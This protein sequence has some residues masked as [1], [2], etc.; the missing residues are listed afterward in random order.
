MAP[1]DS[2]LVTK[3]SP[4]IEGQVPD[5]IQS[6]HP[7][8]VEFLKQYY[9]FLEA[10]ELTVDG[11]IN[12]V[13]QETESTNFIWGEDETRI[14]LE[15]GGGT[16]GKFIEGEI[17]T[18][19]T[20]KAT[21]TVLVDDLSNDTSRMFISS[22]QKFEIGET[23]T[24]STSSATA[25]V[26]TY[27]ANPVQT[28]QQLLDYANTDNTTSLML[29]EMQ[30]Q[31]MD[32]IP[33]T[34]ASGTSK[35]N[36]IK[37]IK[38]LYAAKGTSEGH[39]LFL[40]LMFDEEAET[41]YPT[42]YMLRTSDGNWNKP[43]T[44]R[45]ENTPGAVGS[46]VI[47]Q[48]LT[49]RTS[50][51]TVFII[52]A[53]ELIQGAS[54]VTEFEIDTDS[55]VGTFVEGET[56]Y[57]TGVNSDV[58]QRFVIQ[59]IVTGITVLD[60]GILY[61]VGDNITLDAS[62]GNGLAT[63]T[64]NTVST[65][66]VNEIVVDAGGSNY[67]V[68]DALVFS[69]TSA[70]ISATGY[71]S[72]IGG[73]MLSEASDDSDGS[74]DYIIFE[75]GTNACYP[76]LNFSTHEEDTIV[77]NGTDSSS[78]DANWK[79]V[80][81]FGTPR[82]RVSD[83]SI[84]SKIVEELGTSSTYGEIAGVKLTSG[85]SGYGALPAI[86]IASSYGTGAIIIPT[87][88]DIGS[89]LDAEILDAGFLY[90]EAPS[91]SVPTNFI[92]KDV[93]GTFSPAS[94]LSSHVGTV[95]SYDTN[96]QVLS[97]NI[98]DGVKVKMEQEDTIISQNIEQEEN[99]EVF[100]SRILGDNV[101]QSNTLENLTDRG[102]HITD[103]VGI[104]AQ[105]DLVEGFV[106]TIV[107]DAE[108]I[109]INQIS[110]ENEADYSLDDEK[111]QLEDQNIAGV[112]R[113]IEQNNTFLIYVSNQYT[114]GGM[115]LQLDGSSAG[116]AI[117][118]NASDGSATD[119]GDEILLDRTDASGTD[120]GSKLLQQ[121]DDEGDGILYESNPMVS[122][123]TQRK[124]KFVLDG[125]KIQKFT[126]GGWIDSLDTIPL[127]L[128]TGENIL[129]DG[130]DSNSLDS[131]SHLLSQVSDSEQN[132]IRDDNL[133]SS[134]TNSQVV[135]IPSSEGDDIE[136]E[137]ETGNLLL[138]GTTRN[139]M[140]F[141]TSLTTFH[142]A[143]LNNGDKVKT[144]GIN[145]YFKNVPIESIRALDETDGVLLEDG[146]SDIGVQSLF[147][148]TLDSTAS[149]GVDAGDNI[150]LED[151]INEG[152]PDGGRLL[153]ESSDVKVNTKEMLIL[154]GKDGNSSSSDI[155]GFYDIFENKTINH[156]GSSASRLITE[157]GDG[158]IDEESIEKDS[159]GTSI[160]IGAGSKII[161][162]SHQISSDVETIR[163]VFDQTDSSGSN[164]GGVLKADGI[165]A[166]ERSGNL[167]MQESGI[168]AGVS[169]TDVGENLLYEAEAFLTGNIILDRTDDNDSDFGSGLINETEN[170]FKGKTLTTSGGATG[171]VI[172]SNIAKLISEIDFITTK[173]GNY[174]NTDSLI[175]E[176]VVRIQDSYYYQD[177]SY[178]VR[179]GQSVATYMNE[180]K[181]A[182]HPSGF[183]AFG[184]VSFATLI[185][186]AMPSS[187]GGGRIDVPST[188]FTPELAS[189]LE[190]I[191]NLR[192]K[193]RLDIPKFY[194]SGNLFQKLMLESGGESQF[195]F[196][197]DGTD[198]G[199]AAE[200]PGFD[201][202]ASE[203]SDDDGD[204][205][206]ITGSDDGSQVDA[207][208][209]IILEGTD[210]SGTNNFDITG[211]YSYLIL[212]GTSI[213]DG[214]LND[215]GSYC[216]LSGSAL[217]VYN[218]VD[219]DSDSLVLNGTDGSSTFYRIIH[220]DGNDA[221]SRI[222]TDAII[223]D[224]SVFSVQHLIVSE[225]ANGDNIILNRTD[226]L[227]ADAN[228]KLVSESAA[229]VGDND[230]DKLFLR[231]LTVKISPP[232]PKIL[233]SYGL[234]LMGDGSFTEA[235]SVSTIQLEDALRK[236]GPTINSDNLI[237]DG[238]DVGEKGDV[239][240]IKYGGDPIQLE[241]S[242]ALM[243]G[244]SVS[245]DDYAQVS[246]GKFSLSAEDGDNLALDN[247]SG[248]ILLSEED[249]TVSFPINEFLR[250][251]IMVME[252]AYDRHSEWGRF[253]L[254]G[255]SSDG[256][257]GALNSTGYDY[258]V[259]DGIDAM[260]SG[261]DDNLIFEEQ[262][263]KNKSID[264]NTNIGILM[265]NHH[266]EGG[267]FLREYGGGAVS[268]GDKIILDGT[269]GSSTDAEDN[270]IQEN[271]PDSRI[272]QNS[273]EF[274]LENN[275]QVFLTATATDANGSNSGRVFGLEDGT[276][277]FLSET[278]GIPGQ[279]ILLESGSSSTIGS[280]L[281]L[282]SQVIEI[283]SGIND[284]EIPDPNIGDNS[285]FPTYSTPAI[286][287]TRP[288][289]RM[290]L[291]DESPST[292]LSQEGDT[293]DDV[294]LDGTSTIGSIALNGTN[295]TSSDE[296]S[297]LILDGTDSSSDNIGDKVLHEDAVLIDGGGYILISSAISDQASGGLMEMNGTDG[298]ST[299]AG[300]Y[301]QFE[302]GTH[303][304]L[305]G[306][307]PGFLAPGQDA[308][309]FDNNGALVKTTF[310][311]TNQTYDVLEGV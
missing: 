270:F 27:R 122:N 20:S 230:R 177:F 14:V 81:E 306:T 18:G 182:V 66:G 191:F 162:N 231:Q 149:G 109:R 17:I 244:T 151:D 7:Q 206:I 85:G 310:D 71:V 300:S 84:G 305:L 88:K 242:E 139:S 308:E 152:L 190:A 107:T 183:A 45:C 163:I 60:G 267:A 123:K 118:L 126:T 33:N 169:D 254:D 271:T 95:T 125:S 293:G 296:N 202:I 50:G 196:A 294:V 260:Q 309:S 272:S 205:I 297:S 74:G 86:T 36:L 278:A 64:V 148:I 44:I 56:L 185:S 281:L 302:N 200:S 70:S 58:E 265:E 38:D 292:I 238:V 16:T 166:T 188:T 49:G 77:L 42:K 241:E 295:G 204:N 26:N 101:I 224:S 146:S 223:V 78:T 83:N 248:G 234:G 245:F 251:D 4:L 37:N 154:E 279:D 97:T 31:F 237:L 67:R 117:L 253:V 9:Q 48:I 226:I 68:G 93:T 76:E 28:I 199:T 121:S 12:N 110:L 209:Q 145:S 198:Y 104:E 307:A 161:L 8:F 216:V 113:D 82:L 172:A 178:E 21:A 170:S 211:E 193:L 179:I 111:I 250:P 252:G 24:G 207:G 262:N 59:K 258:I 175:S 133:E 103:A 87:T 217:G 2:G 10:A 25:I 208:D 99:T 232:R 160:T 277:G 155:N 23:I 283:E 112:G 289:G 108:D 285:I 176:D 72:V 299:N 128:E 186:M 236:R 269:D 29:D 53:L 273:G 144:E 129:L 132:R 3:I 263:D 1:F 274:V 114:T 173:V 34:L 249:V 227:G 137:N 268:E 30:R 115:I 105:T 138:D 167:L 168:S 73:A 228:S 94:V 96:T 141:V 243:L 266:V 11:I 55:L 22:Q 100:F 32:I 174:K 127:I 194:E 98:E 247:P 287:S 120:A 288:I 276:G 150:Q 157:G 136:L 290:S 181:R 235:S 264:G 40:R 189:V 75:D 143:T 284:G 311:N 69:S 6:D 184:K 165:S 142:F 147:S 220:E 201:A 219:A 80:G 301:L 140:A 195:N 39:K 90:R 256:S 215:A 212:N 171:K 303:E 214:E 63:A 246:R 286:I 102:L 89:I 203:D 47:G 156:G 233:T 41:F 210:A 79:I 291:Q 280:K 180:L 19:A 52:N 187:S 116:D 106:D 255:T 197:L 225:D 5:F 222:V 134:I 131:G 257:T 159:I 158:I 261:A 298:S 240:D 54:S 65:G 164:A 13:I 92:L 304:S 135:W 275:T 218:L 62:A 259:L 153:G 282:D 213:S 119:D 57:A 43:A 192:I 61:S 35:R 91:V 15:V 124:D 46:E 239:N 51:S 130:T 229:G 221:G